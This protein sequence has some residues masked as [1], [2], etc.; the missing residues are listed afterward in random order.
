[1]GWVWVTTR[2]SGGEMRS[3]TNITLIGRID[4]AS[5]AQGHITIISSLEYLP[6]FTCKIWRE[7]CNNITQ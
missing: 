3:W 5:R 2:S 6:Y 4:H 1:M 7:W